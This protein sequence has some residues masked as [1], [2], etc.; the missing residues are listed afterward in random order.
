MQKRERA[1]LVVWCHATPQGHA[2]RTALFNKIDVNHNGA[3][4]L[5]EIDKA[6]RELWWVMALVPMHL[7]A[8][9]DGSLA[10]L[11]SIDR[12]CTVVVSHSHSHSLT[13]AT[14]NHPSVMCGLA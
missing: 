12:S 9:T 14:D 10:P 2:D 13:T 6:V 5:A 1:D 7:G 8:P 11:P 3:L 4:S